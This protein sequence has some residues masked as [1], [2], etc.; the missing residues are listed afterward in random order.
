MD[1]CRDPMMHKLRHRDPE[2]SEVGVTDPSCEGTLPK[3]A[4][5]VSESEVEQEMD[6][7]V[8]NCWMAEA[9]PS[10]IG[11]QDTGNCEVGDLQEARQVAGDD[12]QP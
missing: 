6:D 3:F 11:T 5:H 9:D 12:H 10:E 8:G 1:P 2:G 7:P 4:D